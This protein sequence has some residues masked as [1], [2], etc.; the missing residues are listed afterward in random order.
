V[1]AAAAAA[2]VAVGRFTDDGLPWSTILH[3][4]E[5]EMEEEGEEEGCC[6]L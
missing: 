5:G 2:A 1:A 4:E 3:E 6:P